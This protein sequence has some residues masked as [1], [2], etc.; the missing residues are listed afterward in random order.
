MQCGSGK[1]ASVPMKGEIVADW[2]QT[3]GA[4]PLLGIAA[5]AIAL[6]LV[7]IMV[8]RVH[9]FLTLI[10]VSALT[11]LATGIPIGLIP[12]VMIGDFGGTLG[13]V[14]L[15]VGLGA[16]L[17]RLIE[18]SGGAKA[19]ADS[20]VN[21]VGSK[22]APFALGAASLLLGFPMFFDAGLIMMLPI[23]FAVA[24]R[25]SGKSVLYFVIPTAGAF[26][27][28]HVFVPPHPGPVAAAEFFEAS[29]GLVL[30]IGLLMAFPVW[31]LTGYLWG[32]Y[33]GKHHFVGIPT[34]FGDVDEDQPVNP[35]KVGTVILL[36]L[37][38]MFLIFMN[39]GMTTL[40][41]AGTLDEDSMIVQIG[42]FVG[43]SGIALLITVLVALVLL[44]YRRGEKGTALEKMVDGALGP[45]CSSS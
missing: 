17:G 4:G 23:V 30:L 20:L 7:L 24:R 10:I 9:A 8:F 3:L 31:Y 44:G 32:K 25:V 26:S 28:M 21:R 38:P 2:T 33:V 37:L 18:G 11:A 1:T 42:Q 40:A 39:T 45:I 15:L 27:V 6:I 34:L 5:A 12:E 22:R 43:T 14:A 29:I 36:L 41:A 19:L 13:S 35:P 16:M